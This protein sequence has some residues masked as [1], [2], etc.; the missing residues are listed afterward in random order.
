[1][2]LEKDLCSND[3]KLGSFLSNSSEKVFRCQFFKVLPPL[4]NVAMKAPS[5]VDLGTII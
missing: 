1:M 3:L 2:E 5:N 4:E